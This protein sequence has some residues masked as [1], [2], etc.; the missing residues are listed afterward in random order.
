[1]AERLDGLAPEEVAGESEPG[2]VVLASGFVLRGLEIG[3]LYLVARRLD[4]LPREDFEVTVDREIGG[5][6][7]TV[8]AEVREPVMR[9]Q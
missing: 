6:R 5:S 2:L 9:W 4:D 8:C 7:G 1:V 3:R